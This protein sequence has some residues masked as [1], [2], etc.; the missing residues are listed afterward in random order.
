M[1]LNTGSSNL[2][3]GNRIKSALDIESLNINKIDERDEDN[4]ISPER[5]NS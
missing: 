2:T 3:A 5:S 4:Y 1:N